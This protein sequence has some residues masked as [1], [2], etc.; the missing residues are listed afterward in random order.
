[1]VS[2][3]TPILP[4]LLVAHSKTK[5]ICIE[6][7]TKH[8]TRPTKTN[9]SVRLNNFCFNVASKTITI[10]Y[11]STKDQIA[12]IFTKPLRGDNF[13]KISSLIMSWSKE[14]R[15]ISACYVIYL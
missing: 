2:S 10:K 4:M 9:L 7:A 14:K 8:R 1:M 13:Y 3:S 6:I 5:K 15:N 11:I 12:Y